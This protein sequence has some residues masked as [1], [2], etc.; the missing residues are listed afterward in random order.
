MREET[1][2]R[3]EVIRD[4]AHFYFYVDDNLIRFFSYT[5]NDSHTPNPNKDEHLKL[6]LVDRS[7]LERGICPLYFSRSEKCP[8]PKV[9]IELSEAEYSLVQKGELVLP[10]GWDHEE[11]LFK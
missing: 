5:S 3:R 11:E 1:K 4:L 9:M 7:T 10:D 2:K 6:I 8:Y